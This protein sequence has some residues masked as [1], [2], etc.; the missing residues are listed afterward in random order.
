MNILN[1]KPVVRKSNII[2]IKSSDLPISC[3]L[4]NATNWNLH[5]RVY[6]SLN[7]DNVAH[8]PYC[9]NEYH[10]EEK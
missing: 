6:L 7:E 8:C 3:P 1:K 9:G 10:L 2:K 4:P 5:P